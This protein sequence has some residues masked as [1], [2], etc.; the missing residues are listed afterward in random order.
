MLGKIIKHSRT[1]IHMNLTGCGLSAGVIYEMGNSLRRARSILVIHL[2]GN[3]GLTTKNMEYLNTRIKCRQNEDIE[4]FTR[5]SQSVRLILKEA[6]I[7][8][9][10]ISGVRGKVNRDTEFKMLHKS[11]PIETSVNDQLIFQRM[12]GHKEDQPGSGQ[13][14]ESSKNAVACKPHYK[15]ECW[16]C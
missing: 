8:N 10:L 15:N 12:L 3:P 11:D 1:L 14:Y 9:N 13:W 6:G 4:R 7:A 2:S 16:I 5:V